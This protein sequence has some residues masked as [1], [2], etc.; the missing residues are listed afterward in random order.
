MDFSC[1]IT[2]PHCDKLN[3]SAGISPEEIERMNRENIKMLLGTDHMLLDWLTGQ[4]C[5]NY[6]RRCRLR[7]AATDGNRND[8]KG[9]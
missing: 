9:M 3:K 1:L 5:S 6:E 2:K 4:Q 8:L 7:K